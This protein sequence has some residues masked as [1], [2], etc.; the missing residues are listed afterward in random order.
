LVAEDVGAGGAATKS[1]SQ[2]RTARRAKNDSD[3]RMRKRATALPVCSSNRCRAASHHRPAV[4]MYPQ[5]Y[6][7][8][9]SSVARPTL[10]QVMKVSSGLA[11][12]SGPT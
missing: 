5:G 8:K 9:L 7:T 12:G 11:S 3:A 10:T 6:G 2:P 1:S 4:R